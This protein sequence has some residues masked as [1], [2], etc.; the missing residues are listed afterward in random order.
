MLVKPSNWFHGST[1]LEENR[2]TARSASAAKQG[3]TILE[4]L[5]QIR[6]T[7]EEL[8]EI[9]TTEYALP[10]TMSH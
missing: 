3:M 8:M 1:S 5:D 6:R 4:V 2:I 10:K 9:G 7:E